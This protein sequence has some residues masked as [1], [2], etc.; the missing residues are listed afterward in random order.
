[1]SQGMDRGA[2]GAQ[3]FSIKVNSTTGTEC[4]LWMFEMLSAD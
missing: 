3:A 2:G 4:Q 1:M